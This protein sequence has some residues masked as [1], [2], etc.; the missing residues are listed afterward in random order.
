[1]ERDEESGSLTVK[2]VRTGPEFTDVWEMEKH[3]ED[4]VEAWKSFDEWYEE[5]FA[6]TYISGDRG[7]LWKQLRKRGAKLGM[8]FMSREMVEALQGCDL[9]VVVDETYP[10]PADVFRFR[11]KWLFEIVPIVHSVKGGAGDIFDDHEYG[12]ALVLDLQ[13]PGDREGEEAPR[14]SEHLSGITGVDHEML[15][16][17]TNEETI[18]ALESR[19]A[20]VLHLATHAYPDEFFPGRGNKGVKVGKLTKLKTAYRTVLSTGCHTGNPLF[21]KAIMDDGTRFFIASMYRT[22]GDDGAIFASGF[23]DELYSGKTPFEAFYEMKYKI[24]VENPDMPDILRFVL[25]VH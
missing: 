2:L 18:D 9:L 12:T 25:Y 16:T 17:L 24:T 15:M 13:G 23:Y 19:E 14:V 10:F 3:I 22:A 1:M 6:L 7:R 21:A 4:G 11:D 8:E 20:D 5:L